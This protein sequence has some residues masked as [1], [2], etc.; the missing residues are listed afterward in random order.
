MSLRVFRMNIILVE[1]RAPL[2]HTFARMVESLLGHRL[3][4]AFASAEEARD[5]LQPGM[6]DLLVVDLDLPGDSGIEFI[7]WAQEKGLGIPAVVWTIHEGRESVYAALKA[8]AVG[9]LVKGAKVHEFQTALEGI[10]EGGAPM[11]PRIARRLLL[12]A[13]DSPAPPQSA[14]DISFRE[15]EV[16]RAVAAGRTHKEI[17]ADLSISPF[18]VR[19]HLKHIY[20]K[21]HA[22]G[23]AQALRRAR[24]IGLIVGS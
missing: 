21:L 2:R 23:R 15:R 13:L 14:G 19:S 8:G 3:A 5:A 4:A 12:D 1:D 9:Y 10:E 22:V 7:R 18:T 11:S 6:A 24:D 17:A 20:R 16:L